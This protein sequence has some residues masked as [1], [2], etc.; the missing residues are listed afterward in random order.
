MSQA[1]PLEVFGTVVMV[2]MLE[3]MQRQLAAV[4]KLLALLRASGDETIN[5]D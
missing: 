5:A 3:S 4:K 2:P 1:T